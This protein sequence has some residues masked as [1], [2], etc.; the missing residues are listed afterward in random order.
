MSTNI[1]MSRTKTEDPYITRTWRY[2][3]GTKTVILSIP[4]QLAK[5]YDIK[6]HTNLLAID[7]GEGILFKK[8]D[9]DK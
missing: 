2:Y 1:Q 9:V 8:L 5:K 3:P 7:T 4:H 6:D